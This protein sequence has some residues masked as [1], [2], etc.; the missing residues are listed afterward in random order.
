MG[1]RY[2]IS[3][4]FFAAAVE[5]ER[6]LGAL[7][8]LAEATGSDHAQLIGIGS[9]Y[10]FGFNWV[11]G[12]ARAAHARF[13]RDDLVTPQTNFRVAASVSAPPDAII[14]EDRY[15]AVKPRLINET[16]LDLCSD[17]DIPYGCQTN[18]RPDGG[19]LLGLALLRSRRAGPTTVEAAELFAAV[20]GAAAASAGLQVVL[21]QDGHRL[22]AGG[23][24]AMGTACFVL[25]RSLTVRAITAA[26][27]AMLHEGAVTLSGGRVGLPQ[28]S[29]ERRLA[30]ML[31]EVADGRALAGNVVVR[32]D[33]G[34]VVLKAHRL[35]LREWNMGFAPF[36][37][38][39]A[40][41]P[42]GANRAD[43]SF[44]RS[45]CALTQAEAEI[46]L[47][48]RA[49]HARDAICVARGIT[50]ET[51]RSHLRALFAKLGVRRETEA[52][53]LLHA[54]LP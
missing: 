4:A 39:V 6:W 52:V 12:M 29:D 32:N 22:V 15:E 9:D 40:R 24:E 14:R 33:G 3:E 2:A 30:A 51:L 53:H 48:L 38:V 13:D 20:R 8:L 17:M 18:L 45:Q 41:R 25:D 35:P 43:V 28:A 44:L 37:I 16:Y 23:F 31:A 5:P 21:E 50:R 27:E 34:V 49:G 46:A 7:A 11:S 47:L 1:E 10:T 36:A 26:A 42:G 54:L 19:G